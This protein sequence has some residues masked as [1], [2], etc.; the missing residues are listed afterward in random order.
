[1]LIVVIVEI[2]GVV[3]P[4]VTVVVNVQGEVL[5]NIVVEITIVLIMREFIETLILTNNS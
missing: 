4:I 1:M 3:L 5:Q 2:A